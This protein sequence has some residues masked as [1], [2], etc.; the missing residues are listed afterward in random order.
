VTT[1]CNWLDTACTD[2]ET[3]AYG[4]YAL[5]DIVMEYHSNLIIT[6]KKDAC[7]EC[8]LEML[9]YLDKDDPSDR[10]IDV[11][12]VLTGICKR[13]LSSFSLHSSFGYSDTAKLAEMYLH[14]LERD[15]KIT[16]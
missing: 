5:V 1:V 8:V 4:L 15:G 14:Q 7:Q 16:I 12:S 11:F 10:T 3:L 13:T 2:A 9:K 6:E